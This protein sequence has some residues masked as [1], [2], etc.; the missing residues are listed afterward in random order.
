MS[1]HN[2]YSLSACNV[3]IHILASALCEEP[4]VEVEDAV[5][6]LAP[7]GAACAIANTGA[8]PAS[9]TSIPSYAYV[10]FTVPYVETML[11][12]APETA[13]AD[14]SV[15]PESR[16]G[17]PTGTVPVSLRAARALTARSYRRTVP[18]VDAPRIPRLKRI[19]L[20]TANA[21]GCA[22]SS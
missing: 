9:N 12:G 19:G 20:S 15:M 2:H 4:A 11:D 17:G 3:E 10:E 14:S 7:L 16:M 1:T 8:H 6:C 22:E 21:P 5:P 18:L 13:R